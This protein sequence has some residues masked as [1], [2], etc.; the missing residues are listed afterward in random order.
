MVSAS[1]RS[2]AA[3]PALEATHGQLVFLGSGA[4]RVPLPQYG[5]YA[6]AKAAVRASAIQLRRELRGRGIAVTYVDP[7]LV[8]TEF[9]SSIGIVRSGDVRGLGGR[10]VVHASRLAGRR[11]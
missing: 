6:A 2:R 7:G 11:P 5:A 9:H 3:L 1:S 10:V 8:D 4:A